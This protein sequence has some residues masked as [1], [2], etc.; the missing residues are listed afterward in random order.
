MHTLLSLC[1]GMG[2]AMWFGEGRN[3]ILWCVEE[4]CPGVKGL[5][6]EGPSYIYIS[7][8]TSKSISNTISSTSTEL[9]LIA[10]AIYFI[11]FLFSI[12]RM[13]KVRI[14][15]RQVLSEQRQKHR[16]GRPKPIFITAGQAGAWMCLEV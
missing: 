9:P 6:Q 11:L 4:A 14:S 7:F 12:L 2:M 16:M 3:E 15:Y 10:S 13:G 8:S 5:A 1:L